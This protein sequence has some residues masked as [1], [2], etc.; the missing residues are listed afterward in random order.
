MTYDG[1]GPPT[2]PRSNRTRQRNARVPL[3]QGTYEK[4]DELSDGAI[5]SLLTHIAVRFAELEGRCSECGKPIL[6]N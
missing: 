6:E 5:G 3:N 4:L 2:T 1:T